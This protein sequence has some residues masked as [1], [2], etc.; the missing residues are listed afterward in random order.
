MEEGKRRRVEQDVNRGKLEKFLACSRFIPKSTFEPERPWPVAGFSNY[1][2]VSRSGYRA[3]AVGSGRR[4]VSESAPRVGGFAVRGKPPAL[5]PL[6]SV[7]LPSCPSIFSPLFSSSRFSRKLSTRIEFEKEILR[8][9][10]SYA[11]K[12]WRLIIDSRVSIRSL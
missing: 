1:G 4:A 11:E 6:L 7:H 10:T 8:R 5:E 9:G 2:G 12:S 3:N